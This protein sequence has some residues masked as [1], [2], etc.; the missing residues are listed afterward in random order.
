[1]EMENKLFWFINFRMDGSVCGNTDLVL[2]KKKKT[3]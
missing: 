2:D 3:I 1:M